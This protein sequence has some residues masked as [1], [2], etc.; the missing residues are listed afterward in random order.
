MKTY[1]IHTPTVRTGTQIT[2]KVPIHDTG[3]CFD[4]L[5]RAFARTYLENRGGLCSYSVDVSSI[6]SSDYRDTLIEGLKHKAKSG[7]PAWV[8]FADCLEGFTEFS[9]ATTVIHERIGFSLE[10]AKA[11]ADELEDKPGIEGEVGRFYR[12]VSTD[13]PELF[14]YK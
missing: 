14:G 13:H 10:R 9:W 4:D 12:I 7:D 1:D 8:Q 11:V 3:F 5:V 2:V 6:G